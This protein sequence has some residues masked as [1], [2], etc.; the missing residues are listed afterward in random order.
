MKQKKG[1]EKQIRGWFPQEPYMTPMKSSIINQTKKDSGFFLPKSPLGLKLVTVMFWVYGVL[2]GLTAVYQFS[3]FAYLPFS[4][5]ALIMVITVADAVCLFVVGAGLLSMKKRW[6]DA[7]IVFCSVSIVVFYVVPLRA[8][9]PLELVAIVYLFTLRSGRAGFSK[10]RVTAAVSAASL[11]LVVIM[12]CSMFTPVYAQNSSLINVSKTEVQQ[13]YQLSDNGHY[14]ATVTI[15]Q[16]K[17][18]DPEHDYYS[19]EIRLNGTQSGLNYAKVNASMPLEVVD[20]IPSWLPQ[21][22]PSYAAPISLGVAAI[23]VGNT[24]HT[25]VYA[26]NQ[27]NGGVCWIQSSLGPKEE[28]TFTVETLVVDQD[29]H[30]NVTFVSEAGF[31]D[32]VFGDFWNGKLVMEGMAV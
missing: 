26:N 21:A 29:A 15:Y 18:Q 2:T 14:G 10:R 11:A 20:V 5:R 16:I 28:A 12:F 31:G 24:D 19:L 32:N 4:A 30:F 13:N 17:D 22:N 3:S 27:N 25:L 6:I 9:L 23:Y 7:A 8:A 1:N